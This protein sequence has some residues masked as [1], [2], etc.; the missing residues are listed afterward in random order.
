M[1]D[2]QTLH[3]LIAAGEGFISPIDPKMNREPAGSL[4]LGRAAAIRN[5]QHAAFRQVVRPLLQAIKPALPTLEEILERDLVPRSSEFVHD[6]QVVAES[7]TD[8]SNTGAA[9][10]VELK[11]VFDLGAINAEL[12]RLSR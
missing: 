3:E 1:T 8:P 7:R 4:L 12:G 10:R 11:V 2:P 5:A 9:Y 6:R